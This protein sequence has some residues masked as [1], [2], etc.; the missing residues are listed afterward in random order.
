MSMV[1]MNIFTVLNDYSGLFALLAFFAAIFIPVYI[2]K[3]QKEDNRQSLRDEL[4]AINES[5]R[6]S[7]FTQEERDHYA[8]K[9]KLEK[10]LK[11]K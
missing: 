10:G 9:S 3:K 1:M 6:L 11:R 5:S 8:K 2:Y 7:L 4:E